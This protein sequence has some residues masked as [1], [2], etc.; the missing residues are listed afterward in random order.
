LG[1]GRNKEI[2][3]FLE[4]NGNEGTTDSNLW[5]TMK[6]VLRGKFIALSAFIK[7]LQSSHTSKLKVHMITLG[8]KKQTNTHGSRMQE[9]IKL[10]AEINQLETKRTIQTINET[11]SCF[12]E[13]INKIDKTLAKC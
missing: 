8:K 2:K 9:I 5:D 13:T 4:L 10:R 7:K 11:K 1:Q 3:V 12:F 6:A